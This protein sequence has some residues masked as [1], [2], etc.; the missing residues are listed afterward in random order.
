MALL[1]KGKH[2][3]NFN[4]NVISCNGHVNQKKIFNNKA[5]LTEQRTLK[6]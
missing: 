1:V 6:M 3:P 2:P 5:D 4:I